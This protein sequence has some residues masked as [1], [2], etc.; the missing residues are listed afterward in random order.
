MLEREIILLKRTYL[1]E[2]SKDS[3]ST[4]CV[5]IKELLVQ[6]EKLKRLLDR[7]KLELVSS[8]ITGNNYFVLLFVVKDEL[9]SL[10]N[11]Q[12]EKLK[13]NANDIAQLNQEVEKLRQSQLTEIDQRCREVDVLKDQLS[14]QLHSLQQDH[15]SLLQQLNDTVAEKKMLICKF[16]DL[17]LENDTL[18]KEVMEKKKQCDSYN[19][20]LKSLSERAEDFE[21]ENSALQAK[22]VEV[23]R[24]VSIFV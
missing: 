3:S 4:Q 8:V 22:L 9:V 15:D 10:L 1:E 19:K 16:S 17:Q 14:G 20:C 6:N 11:S 2:K 12:T 5:E 21:L 24:C 13:S 7:R 23:Q 18:T